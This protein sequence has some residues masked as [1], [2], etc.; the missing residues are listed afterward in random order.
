MPLIAVVVVPVIIEV[1]FYLAIFVN[2]SSIGVWEWVPFV[3]QMM[4]DASAHNGALLGK[5]LLTNSLLT[6]ALGASGGLVF[7]KAQLK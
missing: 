6:V 2:G 1:I 3:Q 4:F 5:T 7:A